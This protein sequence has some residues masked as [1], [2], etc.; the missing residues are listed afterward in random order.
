MADFSQLSSPRAWLRPA[1]ASLARQI[2]ASRLIVHVLRRAA[3]RSAREVCRDDSD[4]VRPGRLKAWRPR[5]SDA[6]RTTSRAPTAF[7]ALTSPTAA[8]QRPSSSMCI[9]ECPLCARDIRSLD[10][11]AADGSVDIATL[12]SVSAGRTKRRR[13]HVVKLVGPRLESAPCAALFSFTPPHDS[14]CGEG[15]ALS[16]HRPLRPCAPRALALFRGVFALPSPLL[17]TRNTRAAAGSKRDAHLLP[18]SST[19]GGGGAFRSSS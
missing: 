14:P 2:A 18:S 5:L 8:A 15:A 9:G 6:R 10:R 12:A 11:T 4:V 13:P 16:S 3:V 7:R 19:G 17:A 1:P